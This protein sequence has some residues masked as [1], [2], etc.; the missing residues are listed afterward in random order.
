MYDR[1]F[2]LTNNID[3]YI[4]IYKLKLLSILYLYIIVTRYFYLP[5]CIA[6]AQI[7]RSV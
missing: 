2:I 1:Y 7:I 5:L 3:T 6:F 4:N